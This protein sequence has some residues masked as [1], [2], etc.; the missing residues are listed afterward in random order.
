MHRRGRTAW[1]L[2]LATGVVAGV[3]VLIAVLSVFILMLSIFLLLQKNTRKIEDLLLLGYS[4]GQVSR[5][6]VLQRNV[7]RARLTAEI[8]SV[9][10]KKDNNL[11]M[12]L[13]IQL[14]FL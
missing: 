10:Y 7:R 13:N 3:G 2:R 1:L 5:P 11:F 14:R 6:Y 9:L 8:G 12:N 4:P